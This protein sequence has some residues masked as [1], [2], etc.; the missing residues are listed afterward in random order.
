[1]N[2][3]W[4]LLPS[5]NS[6]NK[7]LL[8][9][10]EL[11]R[12]NIAVIH[13]AAGDNFA[14]ASE[15]KYDT[16]EKYDLPGNYLLYP[17]NA[18]PHKN[19]QTLIMAFNL[20]RKTYGDSVH[21]VLTGSDLRGNKEIHD[22]ISRYRLNDVIHILD[23]IDRDDMPNLYK[24]AKALVFPSLRRFRDPSFR[25]NG[26]RVSHYRVKFHEYSRSDRRRC[27]SIDRSD[28]QSICDAMYRIID[29]DALREKLILI[30]KTRAT[31]YTYDKV[32]RMHL[33]LFVSAYA[34]AKKVEIAYP[35]REEG[36]FD[37]LYPDGWISRVA[38]RYRGPK[39]IF[40]SVQMDLIGGLPG[41]V[42]DEND[43]YTQ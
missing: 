24:N 19:H 35:K 1:M 13:L 40:R 18:W 8:R 39:K 16:R 2:R 34:K 4:I 14:Q 31:N 38:F 7:V 10:W 30:G 41:T 37:G 20:Y 33:D 15:P 23:Y 29:D 21:L 5:L 28:P 11:F 36:V 25:S 17:A 3:Q 42:P 32:A 6:R 27:V 12:R 9:N 26:N 43:G 22:L